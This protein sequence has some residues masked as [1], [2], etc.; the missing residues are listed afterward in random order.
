M[1]LCSVHFTKRINE[2]V[3]SP[4]E[5]HKISLVKISIALCLG[6]TFGITSVAQETSDSTESKEKTSAV[7]FYGNVDAAIYYSNANGVSSKNWRLNGL[8]DSYIGFGT[9]ETEIE[10][11]HFIGKAELGFGAERGNLLNEVTI[12]ARQVYAGLAGNWGQ[13]TVGRQYTVMT[14]IGWN[15][16]N[17]LDGGWGIYA[18]DPLYFGEAFTYGNRDRNSVSNAGSNWFFG[19]LQQAAIYQY[20]GKN[21]SLEFDYVPGDSTQGKGATKGVGGTFTLGPVQFAA[22]LARQ[23]SADGNAFRQNNVLGA[24]L[25]LDEVKLYISKMQSRTSVG[26][27]YDMYY[28]GIGWQASSDLLLSLSYTNYQQNEYTAFGQGTGKALALVAN[29]SLNSS[30]TLYLAAVGRQNNQGD[31]AL[32]VINESSFIDKNIFAGFTFKF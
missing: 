14:N 23:D 3:N 7:E 12:E 9:P 20:T 4:I 13:L 28:T 18:S 5:R 29:Y 1:K 2:T 32:K 21:F 31:D 15:T 8:R 24:V 25:T 6:V 27:V 11:T 30:T 26:A 10:A 22:A 19:Y 17:P 16:L